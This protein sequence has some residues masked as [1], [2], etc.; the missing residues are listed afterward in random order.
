[1]VLAASSSSTALSKAAP[2]EPRGM[3]ARFHSAYSSRKRAKVKKSKLVK[4]KVL[5]T[6]PQ[7][8]SATP[9]PLLFVLSEFEKVT[10][11]HNTELSK[12]IISPQPTQLSN[13]RTFRRRLTADAPAA[14][15]ARAAPLPSQPSFQGGQR[16]VRSS[17]RAG[18]GG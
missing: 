8:P 2:G 16:S 13:S 10:T 4:R 9:S 3:A 15:A 1:M 14:P 6:K 12:Q 11:I 18:A 17:G 7:K 5:P